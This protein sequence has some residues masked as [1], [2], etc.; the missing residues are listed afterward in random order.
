MK[1]SALRTEALSKGDTVI[2]NCQFSVC[3]MF[4]S[5]RASLFI[6]WSFAMSVM[7]QKRGTLEYLTAE[8]IAVP[9]GFTTRLGGVSQAPLDSMNLAVRLEER[10]E[11]V[12]E[13][14]RILGEAM[15][16]DP[17][18][19]VLTR[20]THTD[21]VRVVTAED[22]LGCF[23]RAYPECDGLVTNVP[24]LALVVFTA[25]CTPILLHD[26][27]TGAVGAVHAGWRGTA[28]EIAARAVE[29]MVSTF[30]TKPCDIRAAIGPN[31]GPCCFETDAD[32]PESM[33][34]TFGEAAEPWIQPQG[35]K[36]YVNLKELNALSL[37]RS[38]VAHV[39][40]S[41]LCTACRQD[42]FWS[43]RRVGN[44][45]GSQGAVIVCK[46]VDR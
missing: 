44:Q 3:H 26:P 5:D 14:Y 12:A 13:N 28:K 45:R 25:D 30:G 24:G 15:G 9:H 20:Q 38:G 16:F 8:G 31:I 35:D 32:V 7:I 41:P 21:L 34:K 2:H 23:H 11:N 10:E 43:H 37:R 40:I 18:N 39:E 19:L 4:L 6:F 22:R 42:L 27:V 36:Y 33:R 29:A 1:V 46:G 17:Q